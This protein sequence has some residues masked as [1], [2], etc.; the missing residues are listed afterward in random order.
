MRQT[1]K[2]YDP[3]SR[4]N[5]GEQLGD[6]AFTRNREDSV[7]FVDNCDKTLGCC[8]DQSFK[9]NIFANKPL[10]IAAGKTL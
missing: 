6:A 8:F 10:F 4:D 1:T 3:L 9:E 2:T 5:A 7:Y